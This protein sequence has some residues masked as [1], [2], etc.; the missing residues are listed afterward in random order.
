MIQ[1]SHTTV[2]VHQEMEQPNATIPCFFC[3]ACCTQFVR[4]SLIE[5]HIIA[6]GL[7]IEWH[8]F[9]SDYLEFTRYEWQLTLR[10]EGGACVFLVFDS[11]RTSKCIIHQFRPISCREWMPS[12]YRHRCQTGLRAYWN[13]K[14]SSSGTLVGTA[15]GIKEFHLFLKTIE[16]QTDTFY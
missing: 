16:T 13:L 12:L 11:A 14:V 4:L 7:V 3:G 15:N 9:K 2:Q 8:R 5:A 1:S 6:D 10:Q